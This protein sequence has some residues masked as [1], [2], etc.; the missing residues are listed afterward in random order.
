M[1][2]AITTMAMDIDVRSVL[3]AIRVPTLMLH[4]QDDH[5]PI[6]AARWMAARIPAARLIEFPGSRHILLREALARACDE[7]EKFLREVS[8]VLE[9]EP[10]P[11]AER[12]LATVLF[13]DI[14]GSSKKAVQLGDRFSASGGRRW[15]PPATASSHPLT[16]RRAQFG[17]PAQ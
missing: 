12:V 10:E 14:V 16:G 1:Y 8:A 2:R 6:A 13:T 7:I 3:P 4:G 15:I 5:V 9:E 11:E 17:A